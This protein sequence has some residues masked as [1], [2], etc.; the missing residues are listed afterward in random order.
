MKKPLPTHISRLVLALFSLSLISI[1]PQSSGAVPA[2]PRGVELSQSDGSKVKVFFKGDEFYHWQEDSG[3]YTVVK[4]TG[5]GDWVYAEPATDGS[6][7]AG[8]FKVGAYNPATLGLTKHL[9][10]PAVI[11][12]AN[13]LRKARSAS[14]S[15]HS[16]VQGE[17]GPAKAPVTTGTMKNL[18]I[19]ARFSDQTTTY[20]KAEFGSL[21]NNIGYTVDGASGSVK[22]YFNE[23]SYNKLSVESTISEWVNLPQP[24]A[25]Y[26]ANVSGEDGNPRQMV[27]DAINAL[28]ATGFNFATAF[29]GAVNSLTIIHSGRGEEAGVNNP[30]YIWSHYWWLASPMVVDG[31]TLQAY[32]TEPELRGKDVDVSSEITRVGVICHETGHF[33]GLPDLYDYGYDSK[34]AGNF[35]LMAFGSWNGD[36]A[37]PSHMSAWCK[38]QLGWAT[39]TGISASNNYSLPRI[40]DHSNALYLLQPAGVPATEY[41]LMENR[42]GFGFDS[43]LP[44]D[45][46]GM[47]IWHVDENR[48]NTIDYQGA[49][50][51]NNDQTHYLV[52]LE[53]A[54]GTQH[55]SSNLDLGADEDYFR[56]GNNIAFDDATNP[57]GKTYTGKDLG[58]RI[59]SISASGDPMTFHMRGLNLPTPLPVVYPLPWKPGSGG[60]HDATGLTFSNILDDAEV[61]IYNIAGERVVGF[62]V[63]KSDLNRKV[64][65]GKNSAGKNVASGV[66]FVTVKAPLHALQ[67]FKIAIER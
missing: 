67:T 53:E 46:R 43:A 20:S 34:G 66:Y 35:C 39:A 48:L 65:D 54:G 30:D 8:M 7:K 56:L 5:T 51:N 12:R 47:L 38:K 55:L 63:A 21:F 62:T 6:L 19:L 18:V 14:R 15:V 23:V 42:Q 52:D 25:Y 32:H 45:S 29:G 26:G 57:N 11:R 40:E 49:T 60:N 59:Q 27:I 17:T 37:V 61:K 44:G 13:D 33:L 22:D 41:F 10:N 36:S 58:L 9:Q 64:W 4:D 50:S 24:F 28:D 16:V 31:I 1:L 2:N 3:G